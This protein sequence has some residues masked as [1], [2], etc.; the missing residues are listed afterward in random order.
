MESGR[1]EEGQELLARAV[2]N[3]RRAA[4][5]TGGDPVVSEHLGDVYLLLDQQEL[6]LGEYEEAM[7]LDPR[8]QEQP[9]LRHKLEQL[10]RELERK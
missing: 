9:M 6:A 2:N 5:L 4:E 7:R 10:R 3:L 1:V 8:W